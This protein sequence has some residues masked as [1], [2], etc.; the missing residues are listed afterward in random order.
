[1]NGDK[2][3]VVE[4][5]GGVIDIT[6]QGR[7]ENMTRKTDVYIL[8]SYITSPVA[9]STESMIQPA[10]VSHTSTE[11]PKKFSLII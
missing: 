2:P 7:I 9:C 6:Q 1:M 3:L 4:V 5:G 10:T 11:T 8:E